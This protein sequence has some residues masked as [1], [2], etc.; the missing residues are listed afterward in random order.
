MTLPQIDLLR[1][2]SA[3]DNYRNQIKHTIDAYSIPHVVIG[4]ALQ[5]AL[6]A[7][8]V[9]TT[10]HDLK[11]GFISIQ[12]DFDENS[13]TVSDNGIGFPNKSELLILG[14]SGKQKSSKTVS[15]MVGVGIKVVLYC[16]EYFSIKSKTTT[17]SWIVELNGANQFKEDPKLTLSIPVP[18]QTDPSPMKS[19]GTVIT[20]RFPGGPEGT[21]VKFMEAVRSRIVDPE[22]GAD[23]GF[24]GTVK[25]AALPNEAAYLLASFLQRYSY[26]GDTLEADGGRPGLGKTKIKISLT[27]KSRGEAIGSFWA[28]RWGSSETVSTE[29]KPQYLG[30]EQTTLLTKVKKPA[31]FEDALGPGGAG[32]SRTASG[33]NVT[34]YLSG[35]YK[36]LLRNAKGE[37]PS[38][39]EMD[40][41]ENR[42]F[43]KINCIKLTIGRI[44]QLSQY[45]PHG[46]RR[47]LSANGV[48]TE[49]DLEIVSGRNQQYVRCVDLV[50][51]LDAELNYGKTQITNGPLVGL[52]RE[53]VNEAYRRTIQNAAAA[54]VGKIVGDGDDVPADQFWARPGLDPAVVQELRKQPCDE[55]DVIALFVGLVASGKL[56]GYAVYGF[57]QS[58]RYDS[59]M[60]VRREC[61]PVD[62]LE[63]H[64]EKDLRTVEFKVFVA[65]VIRDIESEAKDISDMHLLVAWD[66]GAIQGSRFSL[67]SIQHSDAFKSSPKKVFSGATHYLNDNKSGRQ[68]QVLLLKNY[69][70]TL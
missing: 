47:V 54:F 48:V 45:L 4:E 58:D 3:I 64:Q 66:E 25:T 40:R 65:S 9:A 70:A 43:P 29:I 2:A 42:L 17:D 62:L 35:T 13:V 37:Y 49:H 39:S 60:I 46:A 51:D 63:K 8:A 50:I 23:A 22:V 11:E 21:L 67:E 59:R 14:G 61:D 20:Y 10:E 19:A 41:F 12:I 44:P 15:G 57:S 27:S 52:V 18:F 26:V 69:I 53:F 33:F 38:K 5:N 68:L 7:V 31:I 30:V 34:K 24:P 56:E 1:P 36:N 55:N 32:L 28:E 16:A 6:D